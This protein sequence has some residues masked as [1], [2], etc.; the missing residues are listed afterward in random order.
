MEKVEQLQLEN[1]EEE[2][3]VEEAVEEEVVEAVEEAEVCKEPQPPA[4]ELLWVF[5]CELTRGLGVTSMAWN[6]KN[7]VTPTH[8]HLKTP[9]ML[10][11]LQPSL[12]SLNSGPTFTE[13]AK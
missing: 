8:S 5:S 12:C 4:V 9:H 1:V 11:V 10:S 2:E 3:A 13:P 6:K 7:P